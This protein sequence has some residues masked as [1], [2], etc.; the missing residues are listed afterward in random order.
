MKATISVVKSFR[1]FFKN[2]YY[3]ASF[4]LLVT[5]LNGR[6]IMNYKSTTKLLICRILVTLPQYLKEIICN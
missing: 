4:R 1:R 2:I 3:K 5:A 6:V